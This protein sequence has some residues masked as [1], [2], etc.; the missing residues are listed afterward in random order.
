[1]K[2]DK[3]L[4]VTGWQKEEFIKSLSKDEVVKYYKRYVRVLSIVLLVLYVMVIAGIVGW[5]ITKVIC[6][7]G[8]IEKDTAAVGLASE[9]CRLN[10][11]GMHIHTSHYENDVYIIECING[12]VR[13]KG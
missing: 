8:Y 5:G 9:I 10:N 2:K 6:H 3:P 7:E 4:S 13:F 12:T 1:M 11:V